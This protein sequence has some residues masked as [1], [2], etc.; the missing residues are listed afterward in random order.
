MI[1]VEDIWSGDWVSSS[2]VA[3]KK[4]ETFGSFGV[5][6]GA[7]PDRHFVLRTR[8][9]QGEAECVRRIQ[10]TTHGNTGYVPCYFQIFVSPV[11]PDI[12]F[13][14]TEDI[15]QVKIV[16]LNVVAINAGT[17]TRTKLGIIVLVIIV[18]VSIDF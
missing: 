14:P 8:E 3:N 6:S 1:L 16:N 17:P 4:S 10:I 2:V 5:W 13:W 18:F 12:I 11:A 9:T 15:F 7:E